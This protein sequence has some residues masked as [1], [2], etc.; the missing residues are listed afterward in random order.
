[1]REEEAL[2]DPHGLLGPLTYSFCQRLS[3]G[4]GRVHNGWLM[5]GGCF[6][7]A[8]GESGVSQ[9]LIVFIAYRVQAKPLVIRCGIEFS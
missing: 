1:M 9:K 8:V 6:P 5:F 2:W 7:S 4:T 3:G